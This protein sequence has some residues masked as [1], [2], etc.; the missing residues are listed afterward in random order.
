MQCT[1]VNHL[2]LCEP[3]LSPCLTA[4][5]CLAN[6]RLFLRT[7]AAKPAVSINKENKKHKRKK[8]SK[9][10]CNI[11]KQNVGSRHVSPYFD[12]YR[13]ELYWS[14]KPIS[15]KVL[16]SVYFCADIAWLMSWLER[17]SGLRS[18]SVS[19]TD[20]PNLH[21]YSY[22]RRKTD[23]NTPISTLLKADYLCSI[24]SCMHWRR[25]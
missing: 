18:D 7:M 8:L 2:Q 5:P 9:R 25:K 23:I 12:L 19:E 22:V 20:I 15:K 17:T 4:L 24:I 1:T 3:G 10:K 16:V 11:Q 13:L 21:F 14:A 6:N